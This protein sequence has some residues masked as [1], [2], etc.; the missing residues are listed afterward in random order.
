MPPQGESLQ[1]QLDKNAGQP[2]N[3]NELLMIKKDLENPDNLKA[4]K[5]KMRSDPEFK[6]ESI[7]FLKSF[8]KSPDYYNAV[9]VNDKGAMNATEKAKNATVINDYNNL[10]FT[11]LGADVFKFEK[12]NIVE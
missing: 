3:N 4:L 5:E 11:L 6:K 9:N 2:M 8:E 7:A 12:E 1:A 10:M